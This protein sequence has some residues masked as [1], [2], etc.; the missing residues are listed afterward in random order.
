MTV[1]VTFGTDLFNSSTPGFDYS[2]D[3]ETMTILKNVIVASDSSF[4]VHSVQKNNVLLNM[5]A[6]LSNTNFGV[7]FAGAG[8]DNIT[9][10]IG[11]LISGTMGVF[12]DSTGTSTFNNL[13][14]T[15]GT[16][17]HGVEF[18]TLTH[19][20]VFINHGS[21]LSASEGVFLD[22]DFTGGLVNN[23]KLINAIDRGIHINTEH[24]FITLINNHLGA[25]IESPHNAIDA[26][27]G[28]FI[29]HN[30]G[31]VIGDVVEED[32]AGTPAE[33]F[34]HGKITGSVKLTTGNDIFNG[35]GGR[36]GDIFAGSG[37]SQIVG[38]KGNVVIHLGTGFNSV[39]GGPN[40]NQLIFDSPLVGQFDTFKHFAHG[41][42]TI[43]LKMA[44]FPGLPLG[45]LDSAHFQN[46][47]PVNGNP[48]IDYNSSTGVLVFDPDGTGGAAPKEIAVIANH[49]QVQVHASDILVIA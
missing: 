35:T 14:T 41:H 48:Q 47:A 13:G 7:E 31:K 12:M 5:G 36:S 33:I 34:N 37:N 30:S 26:T 46:G 6:V 39:T 11:A 43:V 8:D 20:M 32:S 10:A 38:G 17:T 27:I 44:D 19:G 23:F 28:G 42:D 18:G 4:G 25:I 2:F 3:D 49:A 29:L 21:V 24:T 45:V 22:S 40:H 9:N 1:A 15:V 16:S